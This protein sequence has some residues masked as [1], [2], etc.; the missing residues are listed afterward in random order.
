[1][2]CGR[3]GSGVTYGYLGLIDKSF[4]SGITVN[5]NQ[6]YGIWGEGGGGY[7]SPEISRSGCT[8]S[9]TIFTSS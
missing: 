2:H 6:R 4:I 1:M 3:L 8:I 9:L 7:T 5:N